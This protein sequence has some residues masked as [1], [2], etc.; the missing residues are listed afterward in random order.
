MYAQPVNYLFLHKCTDYRR[1]KEK[2][3]TGKGNA[4]FTHTQTQLLIDSDVYPLGERCFYFILS[5]HCHYYHYCYSLYCVLS[6]KI[7]T[8]LSLQEKIYILRIL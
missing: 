3:I 7:L 2:V 1:T 4:L 8:I 6:F 5:F